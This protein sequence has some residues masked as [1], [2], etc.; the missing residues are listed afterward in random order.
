M[1]CG[2]AGGLLVAAAMLALSCAKP[3]EKT[4]LLVASFPDLDR[5]TK[6]ALPAW[7]RAH[8][9]I[10]IK[11]VSRE[12][13]DHHTAMM[14]ALAT[15][16]GLPDVIAIDRDY[17]GKFAASGGLVDL[18]APPYDKEQPREKFVAF[19]LAQAAGPGGKLAAIPTDIGPGTLLYRKDIIERA[20][21]SEADLTKSWE[22]YLEAGKRIKAAT[23]AYL[24]AHASDIRDIYVR[25]GLVDGEGLFFDGAGKSLVDTPRFVRAFELGLATRRAGLDANTPHWTNEWSE[26]LKRGR[27]AT[28]LMGAWLVGHLKNGIAPDTA[29]KWR[30]ANLPGGFYGSYGGSFYAIPVKAAHKE[31]AWEF[32]KFMTMDRDVQ[33][34]SLRAVNAFPALRAAHSDPVF[35]QP[36]EFLGGQVAGVLWREI[37]AKIPVVPTSRNDSVAAAIVNAEFDKVLTE[38]KDIKAALAD[39]KSLIEQRIRR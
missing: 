8:P 38:N 4:T 21:V 19:A 11:L 5:A 36:V 14:T 33:L 37:A 12:Y 31:A 20:G 26:A 1:R 24:L 9:G 2:T 35:E 6:E 15:G 23:G 3:D 30:A 32:V 39:A 25:A 28:Q 34:A 13:G 16:S 18:A 7:R 22:S 17:I 29:G 10:D 27:V